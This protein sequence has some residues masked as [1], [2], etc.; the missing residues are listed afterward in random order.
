LIEFLLTGIVDGGNRV[1]KNHTNVIAFNGLV[2]IRAYFLA[3]NP[4][5]YAALTKEMPARE[6]CQSMV[7]IGTT[8]LVT[9][10]AFHRLME[11]K[12]ASALKNAWMPRRRRSS[13]IGINSWPFLP[14]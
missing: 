9:D 3:F 8:F 14:R 5:L 2:A 4:L 6:R 7:S 11:M 12:Y 1:S 10:G 13:Y